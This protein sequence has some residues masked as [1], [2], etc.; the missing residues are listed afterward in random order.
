ME[1]TRYQVVVRSGGDNL[2][3]ESW[4]AAL[5][6]HV[7][8]HEWQPQPREGDMTVSVTT[9]WDGYHALIAVVGDVDLASTPSV[10][11]AIEA[12]IRS[13]DAAR[14]EVDLSQVTFLD[15][16]GISGLARGRRLADQRGIA[17]AV[18]GAHGPVLTVLEMTG[19]WTHL[20]G[21]TG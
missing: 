17:Y 4:T 8:R 19:V 7:G 12:A 10:D 16:S 11:K 5:Y 6:S 1:G 14:V 15:T 21:R 9:R 3:I 13:A 2:L 18:V 20:S